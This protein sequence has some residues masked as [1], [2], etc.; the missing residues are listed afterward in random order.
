MAAHFSMKQALM[1]QADDVPDFVHSARRS[2]SIARSD[3]SMRSIGSAMS[4]SSLRS[5]DH[6]GSRRGRK[7]WTAP[8]CEDYRPISVPQGTVDAHS[9]PF[10]HLPSLRPADLPTTGKKDATHSPMQSTPPHPAVANATQR[11]YLDV[12]W[13]LP[14]L[15]RTETLQ[16]GQDPSWRWADLKTP[17]DTDSNGANHEHSMMSNGTVHN[18]AVEERGCDAGAAAQSRGRQKDKVKDHEDNLKS[19]HR[20][21]F[22][23]WPT[24][25]KTF[26]YRFE[27]ARHEEATH[28]CPYHWV[29]CLDDPR[30]DAGSLPKC[31]MC[32]QQDVSYTHILEHDEF[33]KCVGKD[34]ESRTFLRRDH[35]IQHIKGSHLNTRTW[36][37]HDDEGL[38]PKLASAWKTENPLL[39][40]VALYCGFC[41]MMFDK[42]EDRQEHVFAHFGDDSVGRR[43]DKSDWKE[44]E[45]TF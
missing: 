33:E 25:N 12:P 40:K 15:R 13:P 10:L 14:W 26:Q 45:V 5:V 7:G 8:S 3:T 24:C 41:F 34:R 35:L 11:V 43:V 36:P 42:W 1:D 22:C 44:A 32:G 37:Q 23:T 29:C 19:G 39:S 2:S 27:W 38:L 20:S 30:H 28:Y 31:L 6:R 4:C 16:D 21:I 18:Q 9:S 17:A